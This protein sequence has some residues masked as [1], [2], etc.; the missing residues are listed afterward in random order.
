MRK[1]FPYLKFYYILLKSQSLTTIIT[2][3]IPSADKNY[4]DTQEEEM[5]KMI[6]STNLKKIEMHNYLHAK[7]LKNFR[8]GVN[9]YADMVSI[10]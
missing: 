9:E 2:Y 1:G 6:F 4:A 5:R 8:L 10:L 3:W 7:G